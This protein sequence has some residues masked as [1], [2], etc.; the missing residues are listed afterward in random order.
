MS[1]IRKIAGGGVLLLAVCLGIYI[2]CTPKAEPAPACDHEWSEYTV[3]NTADF[4]AGVT[5]RRECKICALA[6]V[7]SVCPSGHLFR[8]TVL[9]APGCVSAGESTYTCTVC[10]YTEKRVTL[11]L[12]HSYGAPVSLGDG[13][14]K[15]VCGRDASHT[16]ITS[17]QGTAGICGQYARCI[18]CAGNFGQ[19]GAH[20][21]A[22]R[23]LVCD[24]CGVFTDCA[25]CPHSDSN[26]DGVCDV[27]DTL[28]LTD[29]Y[30]CAVAGEQASFLD[31]SLSSL[32]FTFRDGGTHTL[33]LSSARFGYGED[34]VIRG[35]AQGTLE[36]HADGKTLNTEITVLVRDG[37]LTVRVPGGTPVLW[38]KF[39]RTE[40]TRGAT[41]T[42]P[43]S[44]LI[45]YFVD[46]G[47]YE[48]HQADRVR[49][50]LSYLCFGDPAHTA[51][52]LFSLADLDPERVKTTLLQAFFLPSASGED[53]V[54][55]F[56]TE[57]IRHLLKEDTF[58]DMYD[59]IF[60]TGGYDALCTAL[61][62]DAGATVD[63]LKNKIVRAGESFPHF[64]GVLDRV[65]RGLGKDGVYSL[66]DYLAYRG[67]AIGSMSAEE[68]FGAVGSST[69]TSLLA[70][71]R[72]MSEAEQIEKL[73]AE[74]QKQKDTPWLSLWRGTVLT[75][76]ERDALLASADLLCDAL[77]DD[78]S[79]SLRADSDGKILSYSFS[80]H[81]SIAKYS[82]LCGFDFALLPSL[83]GSAAVC[84][85]EGSAADTV[86]AS[87][88]PTLGRLT[89]G[90]SA[91]EDA[92]F[93]LSYSGD[94]LLRLTDT[95][96]DRPM[97]ILRTAQDGTQ[98]WLLR[99]STLLYNGRECISTFDDGVTGGIRYLLVCVRAEAENE[100]YAMERS[101]SV[102]DGEEVYG[103]FTAPADPSAVPHLPAPTKTVQTYRFFL[104]MTGGKTVRG[105]FGPDASMH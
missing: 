53:T 36:E 99:R 49:L 73:R 29:A 56:R 48:T 51:D 18:F 2:L 82:P 44:Y 38:R 105:D 26:A 8:E 88:A 45:N 60:G 42:V 84:A 54:F 83:T 103:A 90:M 94:T 67:M 87:L 4:S 86:A 33:S 24:L 52:A 47:G 89:P 13:T 57:R 3:V 69:L 22:D 41:H 65:V 96:T 92:S 11:P 5:E 39:F 71:G 14:H 100:Y 80:I 9:T 31:F 7:K 19:R 46:L 74:L 28:I 34:G 101:V 81:T 75:V 62:G 10:G 12:G 72:G 32:S 79:L 25:L 76:A 58:A 63:A 59:E 30:L 70:P 6:D 21:D 1:K 61:L 15:R 102:T 85:A 78:L 16:E 27:C 35:Y 40:D 91:H 55:T 17:C 43:L 23:D 97:Y 98:T 93:L 50:T 77:K 37:F 64:L 95:E 68:Y 20:P 104:D 66:E